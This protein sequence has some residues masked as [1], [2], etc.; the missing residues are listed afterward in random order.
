MKRSSRLLIGGLLVAV[1]AL[2]WWFLTPATPAIPLTPP[3]TTRADYEP[4]IPLSLGGREMYASVADSPVERQFGL[5]RTTSLPEDVVKLFVF[6]AADLWSFWMKDMLYSIDIIWLDT[7]G[8]IVH[9]E[10]NVAP[11]TYPTSLVPS[12]RAQYVIETNAGFV[13]A[14]NL[15]VGD[16]V[17][18]PP[19]A[20]I[21]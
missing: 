18:L 6:P 2:A 7:A 8:T 16:A 1:L 13:A 17:S 11:E 14:Q 4:L 3:E 21:D 9:I 20:A 10:A 5:S 12:G 15:S 19:V